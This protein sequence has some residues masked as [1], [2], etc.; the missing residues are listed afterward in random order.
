MSIL[1]IKILMPATCLSSMHLSQSM[2][3]ILLNALED[4]EALE[5]GWWKRLEAL[6]LEA[7]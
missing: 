2:H 7:C 3:H 1:S 6:G 4:G 5:E